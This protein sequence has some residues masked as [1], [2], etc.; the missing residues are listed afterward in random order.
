MDNL[1]LGGGFRRRLRSLLLSLRPARPA[2][3]AG[4]RSIDDSDRK[5]A[6]RNKCLCKTERIAHPPGKYQ[7]GCHKSGTYCC[8]CPDA[9]KP[10]RR[11][12]AIELM[13]N[14]PR[15]GSKRRSGCSRMPG[16]HGNWHL[17]CT[18]RT[19][20]SAGV[21]P[22]YVCQMPTDALRVHWIERQGNFHIFSLSF[23]N[24]R[25]FHFAIALT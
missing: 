15:C 9:D 12:R 11:Y 4:F 6:S 14:A 23:Q 21:K 5:T 19:K 7:V 8:F 20:S 1:P 3:F 22:A 13:A 2:V 17:S 18:S 24:E 25:P 10:H 16:K